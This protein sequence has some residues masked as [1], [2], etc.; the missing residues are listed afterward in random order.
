MNEEWF[1][2]SW[3]NIFLGVE[4]V[5]F[6]IEM[7]HAL[8]L[9]SSFPFFTSPSSLLTQNDLPS[10]HRVCLQARWGSQVFR[11]Q[12]SQHGPPR[13]EHGGWGLH[14]FPCLSLCSLSSCCS[15]LCLLFF[16]NPQIIFNHFHFLLECPELMSRFMHIIKGQVSHGELSH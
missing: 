5:S 7:S 9:S 4:I 1:L 15:F 14:L 2:L 6:Q 3:S 12:V 8:P 11:N 10:L 16:R 13:T